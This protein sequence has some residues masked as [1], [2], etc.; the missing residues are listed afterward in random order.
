[1][2]LG[3]IATALA[4]CTGGDEAAAQ[5]TD[6]ASATADAGGD[7]DG[8]TGSLRGYVT[9]DEKQPLAAASVAII[10]PNVAIKTDASGA[11]AFLNVAPGQYDVAVNLLGYDSDIRRVQVEAGT[12]TY[13]N[14]T[15]AAVAATDEAY[16]QFSSHKAKLQ[17]M[18]RSFAWVSSCSYPYTA[19]YLTAH[20]HGVNL[21]A[22]NVPPDLMDNR[23][24][25]NF[26]V[27]KGAVSVVS[28]MSWKAQ[29]SIADQL[30]LRLCTPV[31][32]AVLDDCETQYALVT[33]K[34]PVMVTWGVPSGLPPPKAKSGWVMSAVW[35][36]GG[37]ATEPLTNGVFL[38]QTIEMFNSVWYNGEPPEDWSLTKPPAG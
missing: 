6:T 17:C 1:M 4:G 20:E 23:W 27:N 33:G 29:S 36:A 38:D 35:P 25:Y 15:I 8:G 21:S 11:Y 3:I 30:T 16:P 22:Y 18:L 14:F 2:I 28:E 5:K 9:D 32:D 19:V 31:Y 12:T 37:S 24:R 26:S 10:K 13:A 34:S 7:S